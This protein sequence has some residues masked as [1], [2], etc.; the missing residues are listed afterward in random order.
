[1][2]ICQRVWRA[3]RGWQETNPRYHRLISAFHELTG[4]PIVRNTSF[5]DSEPIVCSPRDALL[6]LMKTRIAYLAMGDYLLAKAD[7]Q[8]PTQPPAEPPATPMQHWAS[9]RRIETYSFFFSPS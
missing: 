9:G 7:N 8:K 3:P 4:V 6:T 5:N 2:L 1:M